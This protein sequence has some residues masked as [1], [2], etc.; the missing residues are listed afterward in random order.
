MIVHNGIWAK[1]LRLVRIYKTLEIQSM[2]QSIDNKPVNTPATAAGDDVTPV[3]L[4][5]ATRL[6]IL[7]EHVP[8]AMYGLD[9]HYRINIW[10]KAAQAT[11]GWTAEEIIGQAPT[12]VPETEIEDA[13][14][15]WESARSGLK[16]LD[17]V[18]RR[19]TKDGQILHLTGSA[20]TCLDSKGEFFCVIVSVLNVTENVDLTWQL[21]DRLYFIE[22]LIESIPNPVYFKN[23]QGRYIGMN[24]AYEALFGIDRQFAIGRTANELFAAGDAK[25]RSQMDQM[26]ILTEN[27]VTFEDHAAGPNGP[28]ALQHHKALYK[29]R[30]GEAAGIVGTCIDISK[31]KYIQQNLAEAEKRLV[32][33]LHGSNQGMWDFDL[34]HRIISYDSTVKNWLGHEYNT[35]PAEEFLALLKPLDPAKAHAS[36]QNVLHAK[37]EH[38]EAEYYVSPP[39]GLSR[40]LL[41]KGSITEWADQGRALRLTGMV[42]DITENKRR[43]QMFRQSVDQLKLISDNINELVVLIDLN[44][45]IVYSTSSSQQW[46]DQALIDAGSPLQSFLFEDDREAFSQVVAKI[47][48]DGIDQTLRA[49]VMRRSESIRHAEFHLKSICDD[50]GNIAR[51]LLVGRD[52]SERVLLDQK[53]EHLAHFDQLTGTANRALLQS[54]A[55][56][57]IVRAKRYKTRVGVVFIDL[58]NFKRV[59]DNLGHSRG[60]ELLKQVA[61]RLQAS[62][63]DCDTV[64]RQGGDEFIVLLE[65]IH[66]TEEVKVVAD[67]LLAQFKDPFDLGAVSVDAGASVGL[68]LYPD[69]ATTIDDLFAK[70]DAAMYEAKAQG[71]NRLEL[72]SIQINDSKQL[73]NK[74]EV[75]LETAIERNEFSLVY[76]PQIDLISGQVIGAEAL[77]R[78][79]NPTLGPIGPAQFIPVAEDTGVILAIGD[80]VLSQACRQNM[81]WRS[82]GLAPIRMAVNVSARQFHQ[83]E[84]ADRVVQIMRNN[85]MP[86]SALELELTESVMMS[87][88]DAAMQTLRQLKE[89][90]VHFAL[91][92]FGTGYSSLSYLKRFELNQLKIDRSFTQDLPGDAHD[93]AIVQAILAMAKGLG[94]EVTAEGIETQEQQDFMKAHGCQKGQG[95]LISK[96][97]R[98]EEFAKKFLSATALAVH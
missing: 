35:L 81:V 11:Y 33:A 75:A 54:R 71:K 60:D 85:K 92:D 40:I 10:N 61:N 58:D 3:D 89:L 63:R 17:R 95:Y 98:P 46:L 14:A 51:I 73:R 49:R 16:V 9:A 34:E 30:A 39:N 53:L 29:G 86:A 96:P 79:D 48:T 82:Q 90:G 27:S 15:F 13:K 42:S 97:I 52:I 4:D 22:Q 66:S 26:L 18:I 5:Q 21:D 84:F 47:L 74:L 50:D 12:F 56:H 65:D 28:L 44:C 6:A 59:N 64:A 91:D 72:F 31:E 83:A 19:K 88:T 32:L 69:N 37:S 41:V 7:L 38:Y 68:A 45:Q 70:A 62:V 23:L 24:K 67:R 1:S 76:Q 25:R 36:I 57:A 8:V 2:E 20:S 78:W 93:M 80:W 77:L 55:E 43:D 87:N 94:I